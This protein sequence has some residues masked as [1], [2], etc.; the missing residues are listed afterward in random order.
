K[1]ITDQTLNLVAINARYS[2]E[3]LAHLI[4]Y[5][6]IHGRFQGEIFAEN[7]DALIVNGQRIWIVNDRNPANLPWKQLNV[8]LVIESTGKFKTHD[9]ASTHIEAGAK[10]VIITAPGKQ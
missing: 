4:K 1:M 9:E 7:D 2:A 3:T 8:D 6:T 10:K 5:D